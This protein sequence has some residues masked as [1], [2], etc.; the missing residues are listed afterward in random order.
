MR[1]ITL[2]KSLDEARTRLPENSIVPLNLGTKAL[3]IVRRN[4]E[5]FIFERNCPHQH[6]SLLEARFNNYEEIIC[7]L[8]EYRFHLKN[9]KEAQ[10]RCRE[11]KTYPVRITQTVE[12]GIKE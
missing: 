8:H 9:G 3:A 7:P 5:L 11:L 12:I 1:W 2:F 6:A 4:E 10:Q